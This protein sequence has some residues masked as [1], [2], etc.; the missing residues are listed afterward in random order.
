VLPVTDT[1]QSGSDVVAQSAMSSET[2][3]SAD[4]ESSVMSSQVRDAGQ[5]SQE[6]ERLHL[7]TDR[8]PNRSSMT[9]EDS[10][11][12]RKTDS[13]ISLE[14]EQKTS[15]HGYR[16]R[17]LD[18]TEIISQDVNVHRRLSAA[19]DH[20]QSSSCSTARSTKTSSLSSSRH[21]R[22]GS[23]TEPESRKVSSSRPSRRSTSSRGHSRDREGC[24]EDTRS[25]ERLRCPQER[26][27]DGQIL[28]RESV[29]QRLGRR[30]DRISSHE[31]DRD[32]KKCESYHQSAEEHEKPRHRERP[33]LQDTPVNKVDWKC[34]EGVSRS[35][36]RYLQLTEDLDRMSVTAGD[37]SGV[38]AND[39]EGGKTEYQAVL[40]RH[41]NQ[42]FVR[43]DNVALVAILN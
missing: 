43:G 39:G 15:Q 22:S 23:H 32:Q 5:N 16:A 21:G 10:T 38:K 2:E 30:R 4:E 17:N 37:R 33:E 31:H 12:V 7:S 18:G 19:A 13:Q 25:S 1:P 8:H 6:S 9:S 11:T 34:S 14:S 29:F 24:R 36:N 26:G 42:L 20:C 35:K 40:K 3:N 41:V 27:G 28:T